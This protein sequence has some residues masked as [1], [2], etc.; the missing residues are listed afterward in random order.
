MAVSRVMRARVQTGGEVQ[1]LH[2]RQ[3][4]EEARTSPI[5]APPGIAGPPDADPELEALMTEMNARVQTAQAQGRQDGLAQ[6][7]LEGEQRA[8]AELAP[9]MERLARTIADLSATR[10]AFRREAEED[11]VRLSLGVARR[12]LHRELSI[13]PEALT[14]VIRVALGKFEAREL[15]RVLV[16]PE[17]HAAVATLVQ[18][19][20]LPR[21]V[22][23]IAD[24]TLERGAAMFETVKGT[25]DASVDT[26]L[27][28]I[29]RGFL[30]VLGREGRR[31]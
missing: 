30:D 19:L 9:L 5:P 1:S 29:E 13:D 7:R 17:D 16:S 6:G 28:E 27:D 26:Q 24:P 11:V 4:G 14:G 21:R 12:I 2:W 10:D 3:V 18:S 8:R 15:H 23:V 25:L 20:R 31:G 22:E